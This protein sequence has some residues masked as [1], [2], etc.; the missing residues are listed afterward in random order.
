MSILNCIPR[1]KILK[2]FPLRPFLSPPHDLTVYANFLLWPSDCNGFKGR[3]VKQK[4]CG[5]AFLQ[6]PYAVLAYKQLVVLLFCEKTKIIGEN[7][8]F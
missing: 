7:L 3:E 6:T 5:Q 1:A 4:T 8:I 2:W